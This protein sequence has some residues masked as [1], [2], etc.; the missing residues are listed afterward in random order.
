RASGRRCGATRRNWHSRGAGQG[1]GRR[2]LG[3]DDSFAVRKPW[4]EAGRPC[5]TVRA[6]A[7]ASSTEHG[8][9][10]GQPAEKRRQ[11]G[12]LLRFELTTAG[13]YMRQFVYG[14]DDGVVAVHLAQ[15]A[16]VISGLAEKL[17]LERNDCERRDLESV[18]EIVDTDLRAF[19][20]ARLV[21][22]QLRCPVIR[23]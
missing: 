14:L 19:G 8:L 16:T 20:Y 21:D 17:R 1:A 22:D 13:Q 12:L 5:R 18:G 9:L 2:G 7:R 15:H 10:P 11:A 4:P 6:R 23:S 3:S